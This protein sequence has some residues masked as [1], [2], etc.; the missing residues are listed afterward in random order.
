MLQVS[1][2][3]QHTEL[4]KHKLA[5]KHFANVDLVDEVIALTTKESN[6]KHLLMR[7]KQK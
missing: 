7:C 5:I 4:A 2:L 3:R 1:F 6:Y